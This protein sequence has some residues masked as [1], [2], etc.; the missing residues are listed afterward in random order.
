M[1]SPALILIFLKGLKN[2]VQR[3][4]FARA[5]EMIK[6]EKADLITGV[7][8]TDKRAGFISYIPTS[9]YAVSLVFYTQKG[10]GHLVKTYDDLYKF[11]IGYS[12]HLAGIM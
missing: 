12:L 5:L 6:T 10:R 7:A 2:I 11:K 4:P 8:Y 1:V 9:Y 3:H